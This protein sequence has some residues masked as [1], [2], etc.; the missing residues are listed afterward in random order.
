[1]DGASPVAQRG[2]RGA[3]A[4]AVVCPCWAFFGPSTVWGEPGVSPHYPP[5]GRPS[6]PQALTLATTLGETEVWDLTLCTAIT[7]AMLLKI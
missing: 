4:E 3:P 2:R 5:F 6:P 1:M 7:D